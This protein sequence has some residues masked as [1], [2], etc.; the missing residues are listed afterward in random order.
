MVKSKDAV[1]PSAKRFINGLKL[2]IPSCAVALVVMIF[3][4]VDSATHS[5]ST[6]CLANC[7]D[8]FELLSDSWLHV[9]LLIVFVFAWCI[10]YSYK[11]EK[12]WKAKNGNNNE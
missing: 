4:F 10:G 2:A 6:Q 5:L 9:L 11:Y 8:L 3:I 12:N 7:L 1:I